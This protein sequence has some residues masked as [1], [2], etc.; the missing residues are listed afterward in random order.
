VALQGESRVL[1]LW[2]TKPT[3]VEAPA[4]SLSDREV[5]ARRA[6]KEAETAL[7]DACLALN[8]FRLTHPQHI[9]IKKIGDATW[10]Q[11]T[12]NDPELIRLSSA[13]NRARFDRNA[14]QK[15]WADLYRELH[16]ETRYVAGQR[17][18]H[19]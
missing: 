16:P 1:R 19:D 4:L 9:P 6:W 14:K 7:A 3:E 10:I 2:K 8:R 17:V 11:F 12:P 13:E 18:D 5:E 15:F